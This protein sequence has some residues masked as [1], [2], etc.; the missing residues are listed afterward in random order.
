MVSGVV[1]YL[2]E[3]AGCADVIELWDLMELASK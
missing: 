1:D 3:F 2:V